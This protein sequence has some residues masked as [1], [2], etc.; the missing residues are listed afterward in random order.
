MQFNDTTNKNGLIQSFEFWTRMPDG[1]VTGT[2]L[3]QVTHRINMAYDHIMPLLLSYSDTVRFDDS[4]NHSNRP[5]GKLNLTS[6]QHDYTISTDSGGISILNIT[7]V[8]ILPSA[9]DTEYITLEKMTLDDERALDA[10]SPNSIITGTP[11]HWLENGNTIF[12]YPNPNYSATNGIKIFFARDFDR[13]VSTDTTQE[14][15]IPTPFHE[16]LALYAAFDWNTVNRSDDAGLLN[17]IQQRI[18][19][20]VRDIK[21]FIALR[22]P[23][24]TVITSSMRNFR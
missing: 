11:S 20:K 6:G 16:L 24:K 5:I 23:T 12:L 4:L 1:T 10:M 2:L 18:N 13:F 9:T 3:K 8:R 7:D 15:G 17:R 14:P 19:E 22:N 21:V